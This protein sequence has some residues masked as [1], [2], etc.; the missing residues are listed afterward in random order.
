MLSFDM[1]LHLW[2]SVLKNSVA[3]S[4]TETYIYLGLRSQTQNM[5]TVKYQYLLK[6]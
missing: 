2:Y 4:W 6:K 5:V 3:I 1:Q